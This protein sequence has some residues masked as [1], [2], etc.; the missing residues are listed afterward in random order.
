[1]HLK[2]IR[3]ARTQSPTTTP[4][5]GGEAE[6]ASANPSGATGSTAREAL[7]KLGFAVGQPTM[8]NDGS[9]ELTVGGQVLR[10]EQV[11]TKLRQR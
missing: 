7:R 11:L 3:I 8:G 2:T 10:E 5:G 6:K 4:V 9:V 1:M